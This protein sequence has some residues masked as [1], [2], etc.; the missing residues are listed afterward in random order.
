MLEEEKK[1][2]RKTW[3]YENGMPVNF[4]VTYLDKEYIFIHPHEHE[5]IVNELNAKIVELHRKK[6]M[7]ATNYMCITELLHSKLMET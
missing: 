2:V 6:N 4:K 5:R 7:L 3:E 1:E